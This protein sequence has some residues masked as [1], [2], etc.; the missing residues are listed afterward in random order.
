M[1]IWRVGLA[2]VGVFLFLSAGFAQ[3]KKYDFNGLEMNLGSL[4]RLS[5]A[6]SRSISAENFTGEKGKGGSGSWSASGQ[7]QSFEY[8]IFRSDKGQ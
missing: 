2:L 8:A 1:K 4:P 7:K 5:N 3:E 6:V